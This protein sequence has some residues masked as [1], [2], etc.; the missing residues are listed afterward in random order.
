MH[1]VFEVSNEIE[2]HKKDIDKRT[3]TNT[4]LTKIMHGLYDFVIFKQKMYA[5]LNINDYDLYEKYN[6]KLSTICT[7]ISCLLGRAV[8]SDGLKETEI[9]IKLSLIECENNYLK[10]YLF[11]SDATP[12]TKIEELNNHDTA[13]RRTMQ[14][15]KMMIIENVDEKKENE[16]FWKAENS[17]IKS[18]ITY[19]ICSGSDTLYVLC[20]T[21]KQEG[22]FKKCNEKVYEQI[23]GEFGERIL[24][25]NYKFSKGIV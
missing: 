18:I 17:R 4:L 13:A 3:E 7:A 12:S 15:R 9:N 11:K 2:K 1:F 19:A 21:A 24:L 8:E 14:T 22:T 10:A 20:A 6:I 25:E 16:F 5:N 23:F